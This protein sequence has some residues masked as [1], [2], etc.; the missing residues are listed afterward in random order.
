MHLHS[1]TS[2]PAATVQSHSFQLKDF[3]AM[4][5][6]QGRDLAVSASSFCRLW[7]F[8]SI[9]YTITVISWES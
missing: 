5:Q 3:T 9:S 4:A 2:L 6:L 1:N 8:S 7:C